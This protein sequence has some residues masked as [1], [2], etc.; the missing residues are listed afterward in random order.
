M[1]QNPVS[2]WKLRMQIIFLGA[3]G[4]ISW[5]ANIT[6]LISWWAWQDGWCLFMV[7]LWPCCCPASWW[8]AGGAVLPQPG[9]GVLLK[10]L[11]HSSTGPGVLANFGFPLLS[12]IPSSCLQLGRCESSSS[13][14]NSASS[15]AGCS[16][17]LVL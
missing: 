4:G 3:G 16:V 14:E 11:K 17:W 6:A 1:H 8:S 10:E 5:L 15:T 7:C 2:L 9:P 12:L 13:V